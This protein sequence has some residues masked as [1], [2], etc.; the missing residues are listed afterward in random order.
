MAAILKAI[1]FKPLTSI[2][3]RSN[4]FRHTSRV[5][6]LLKLL[7]SYPPGLNSWKSGHQPMTGLRHL[8]TYIDHYDPP[9][10]SACE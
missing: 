9:A 10:V 7:H 2:A 4:G 5:V 6:N 1:L 8:G 3:I